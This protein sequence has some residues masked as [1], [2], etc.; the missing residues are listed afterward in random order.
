MS[1]KT[2]F[3][4]TV[5]TWQLRE[6]TP[7]QHPSQLV[8]GPEDSSSDLSVRN[9]CFL[10]VWAIHR[11]FLPLISWEMRFCPVRL[12]R[13][14]FKILFGYTMLRIL[15][16][17]W[18]EKTWSWFAVVLATLSCFWPVRSLL[19]IIIYLYRLEDA[20]RLLRPLGSFIS[21]YNN[22]RNLRLLMS[23]AAY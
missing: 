6:H 10:G 16:R 21:H 2:H 23:N 4:N 9:C 15:L 18:F 13:S 22:N 14:L 12:H 3:G 1:G 8:L 20:T 17:Q 5:W 19:D 7:G 11:H